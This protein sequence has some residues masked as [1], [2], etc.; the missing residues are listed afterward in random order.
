MP[1][2][3][4]ATPS[5]HHHIAEAVP[6]SPLSPPAPRAKAKIHLPVASRYRRYRLPPSFP[7]SSLTSSPQL[8]WRTAGRP[9]SASSSS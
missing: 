7:D 6:T 9:S 8:Q 2:R 1:S 4:A 5:P 3:L